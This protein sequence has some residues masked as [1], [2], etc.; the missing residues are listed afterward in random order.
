[1]DEMSEIEKESKS[2]HSEDEKVDL[3]NLKAELERLKDD[4]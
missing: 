1:M 4:F 3:G 2:L